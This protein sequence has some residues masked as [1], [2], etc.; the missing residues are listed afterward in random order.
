MTTTDGIYI[1]GELVERGDMTG[2]RSARTVLSDPAVEVAVLE[3][4]RGG[5]ARRGLGYDWSDI[6]VLTNIRADHIGQDGIRSLKDILHI[7]SLV[8]ERVRE[9]GTLILNADDEQLARLMENPRV[10]CV[11]KRVVYFSLSEHHL[12]INRHVAAGGTAYFLKDGWI[13]EAAGRS[14]YRIAQAHTLPVT[15]KGTARFQIANAMAAIAAARAYGISREQTAILIASFRSELHNTGR[16]NLYEAGGGYVMID[17]GHN[18]DAF[19]AVAR[20]AASWTGRKV[21]AIIGVPGDRGDSLIAQAGRA[22]A[23]GFERIIIK[24]DKDLR[25]RKPGEVASLLRQAIKD[26]APERECLVITDE[27]EALRRELEGIAYGDIVVMFYE[28]LE[29]VLETLEQFGAVPVSEIE[30]LM[31]QLSFVQV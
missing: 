19:D 27:R 10:N 14:Q 4:A 8:A 29:P 26:E 24:E 6:A 18:P 9:G 16:A 13:V 25:G 28:K 12:L 2:P 23:R 20:M 30:G 5:I 1:G 17:Y 31:P 22:A 7:K 11:K 3:T 15:M 21:S